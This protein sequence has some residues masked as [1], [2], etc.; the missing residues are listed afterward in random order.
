MAQIDWKSVCGMRDVLIHDSIGVD[1]DEDWNV[2]FPASLNYA[3]L[4]SYSWEPMA[5][6]KSRETGR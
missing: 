6:S 2:A 5:P 4:W 1:L 3:P